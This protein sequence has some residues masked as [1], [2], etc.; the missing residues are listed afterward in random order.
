M[1]SLALQ[2]K[3]PHNSCV[4]EVSKHFLLCRTG[5]G[6]RY[7][8]KNI[9]VGRFKMS[10]IMFGMSNDFVPLLLKTSA[11]YCVYL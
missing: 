5:V 9:G 8:E 2:W 3:A 10:V 7:N 4:T 11:V 1:Y 6:C